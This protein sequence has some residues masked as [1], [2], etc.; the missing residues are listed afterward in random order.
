MRLIWHL[1]NSLDLGQLATIG[2]HMQKTTV[3]NSHSSQETFLE[4]NSI[5]HKCCKFH[6]TQMTRNYSI[7][8]KQANIGTHKNFECYLQKSY[9]SLLFFYLTLVTNIIVCHNC[10]YNYNLFLYNICSFLAENTLNILKTTFFGRIWDFAALCPHTKKIQQLIQI[11]PKRLFLIP[12]P[13]TTKKI[14]YL[15]QHCQ[16]FKPP[17][18]YTFLH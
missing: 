14:L 16:N 18:F 6:K 9:K 1:N 3:I 8:Q 13:Q 10:L 15:K 12:I 4:F 17:I 2:S 7:L 11:F 5:D